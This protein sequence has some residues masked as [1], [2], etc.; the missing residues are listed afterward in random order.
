[1]PELD[2]YC[3]AL[4]KKIENNEPAPFE[5]VSG[6]WPRISAICQL[7]SQ[8]QMLRFVFDAGLRCL[9]E[10]SRYFCA[11]LAQRLPANSLLALFSHAPP[12]GAQRLIM[13]ILEAFSLTCLTPQLR[14]SSGRILAIA[15]SAAHD[16]EVVRRCQMVLANVLADEADGSQAQRDIV[17]Y[18]YEEIYE[19]CPAVRDRILEVSARMCE[20]SSQAAELLVAQSPD[21]DRLRAAARTSETENKLMRFVLHLVPTAK[22][23][24][25]LGAPSCGR[26]QSA[27]KFARDVQPSIVQALVQ[28]T[29]PVNT[30]LLVFAATLV[31]QQVQL[32]DALIAS[33]MTF[34]AAANFAPYILAILTF[35]VKSQRRDYCESLL[36]TLETVSPPDGI[37]RWYRNGIFYLRKQM[38]NF[39]TPREFEGWSL[40]QFNQAVLERRIDWFRF[41]TAGGIER[42]LALLPEA[43]DLEMLLPLLEYCSGLL[44]LVVLPRNIGTAD[45]ADFVNV[46]Q[47]QKTF[48]VQLSENQRVQV[49]APLHV[50]LSMV[51][52]LVNSE[53]NE[54]T[55]EVLQQRIAGDQQLNSIIPLTSEAPASHL[56]VLYRGTDGSYPQINLSNDQANYTIRDSLFSVLCDGYET[57]EK[58]PTFRCSDNPDSASQPK[59]RSF[60]SPLFDSLLEFVN[61]ANER[62]AH[63][64]INS[65]FVAKVRDA[66]R[67]PLNSIGRLSPSFGLIFQYPQLFPFDLRSLAFSLIA[68]DP[69]AAHSRLVSEFLTN[70]AEVLLPRQVGLHLIVDRQSI[71]SSG[72]LLLSR[73]AGNRI[74]FEVRFAGE[75]GSGPGVTREFFAQLSRELRQLRDQWRPGAF[76]PSPI[77]DA[78]VFRDVGVLAAKALSMGCV[79]DLPL[80]PAFLRLVCGGSVG[81]SDVDA[82]LDRVLHGDVSGV[83]FECPGYPSAFCRPGIVVTPDNQH[84]FVDAVHEAVVGG[85]AMECAAAF[86]RGFEQVLPIGLLDIFNAEEASRLIGGQAQTFDEAD[87]LRNTDLR[88]YKA[89]DNQITDLTAVLAELPDADTRRFI[90]FVTG[91]N[92][93]PAGGLRALHPKLSIQKMTREGYE[94]DQLLPSSFVCANTLNLPPYSSR[95]ILRSKLLLAIT[96]GKDSFLLD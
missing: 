44:S 8:A 92:N 32:T 76:F 11:E 43:E 19:C 37:Q 86:R 78:S 1:V 56:S 20:R 30:T 84:Q 96:H 25:S 63:P 51:E 24:E 45:V 39:R 21:V 6:H 2:A 58:C 95:T 46:L 82:E 50:P 52:G 5:P 60:K 55:Q 10:A 61:V 3:S 93:L 91:A 33:L 12:Q 85:R 34:G 77:A 66:M 40:E 67:Y 38:G 23:I 54:F 88:G 71:L 17:A 42:C 74:P 64:L 36:R 22:I 16:D 65:D 48:Q 47:S 29:L 57:N 75:K 28:N 81:L 68:L 35:F 26:P 4:L 70:P 27:A 41:L 18:L 79:L 90:S 59:L 94:S 13:A 69:L 9:D 7:I 83:D 31:A 73:F 53:I 49:K 80:S 14:A 89:A 62:L 15:R 72:R 87:F